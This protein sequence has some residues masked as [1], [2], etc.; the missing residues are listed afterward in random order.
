MTVTCGVVGDSLPSS[1][2]PQPHSSGPGMNFLECDQKDAPKNDDIEEDEHR[3]NEPVTVG[4]SGILSF[5]SL[6]T[7]TS[8]E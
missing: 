3:N 2:S 7:V 4:H 6:S 8:A 5:A 1:D